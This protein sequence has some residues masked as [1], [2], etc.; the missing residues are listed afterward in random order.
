[1][2]FERFCCL[3]LVA[4]DIIALWEP[5]TNRNNTDEDGDER[6]DRK[7][8]APHCTVLFHIA[9]LSEAIEWELDSLD[10]DRHAKEDCFNVHYKSVAREAIKLGNPIGE[11]KEALVVVFR[12]FHKQMRSEFSPGSEVQQGRIW[13]FEEVKWVSFAHQSTAI[14]RGDWRNVL[15]PRVFWD[16]KTHVQRWKEIERTST[17]IAGHQNENDGD[18]AIDPESR[19]L[20]KRQS[21]N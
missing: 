21:S 4:S 12:V 17:A 9:V 3:W 1:M 16:H 20:S 5:Y 18:C 19:T 11:Q 10:I 8:Q 15:I 6:I 14:Q 7:M 13:I 2:T